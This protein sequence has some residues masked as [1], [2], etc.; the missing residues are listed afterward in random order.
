MESRAKAL[1]SPVAGRY[2]LK[3]RVGS[4]NMS[5]VYRA[6]DRLQGNKTVAVKL[7]NS[8]HDDVLRQ[9]L[10]HRELRALSRV[11]HPNIVEVL[12]SGWSEEHQCHFLVL[13]YLPRTLAHEI[14]AHTA[15]PDQGWCWPLMRAMAAALA[16][17]HGEGIVHR[18]VKPSNV[19]MEAGAHPKLADFGISWLRFELSKGITVSS[20]W[21]VG[22]AAPE[23]RSQQRADER[24]DIYALGCVFYHL[25]ARSEPPADGPHDQEIEALTVPTQ[26]MRLLRRMLAQN[27]AD[28]FQDMTQVC[29][30]LDATRNMELLPDVYL[31]VT[32][33]ARRDLYDLGL[34]DQTTT[35]AACLFLLEELG[36]DNPREVRML[37]EREDVRL[38]TET[39][40]LICTRDRSLPILVIKAVHAPYQPQ[41][42]QQK[43]LALSARYLW[44]VIDAGR[45]N[46]LPSSPALVGTLDHLS[47]RLSEQV[48]QLAAART[49]KR[50]RKDFL[51]TWGSAL[52]YL[53]EQLDAVGQLPYRSLSYDDEYVVF[54]LADPAPDDLP[55]PTNA[56]VV[57]LDPARPSNHSF[58]GHVISIL[59]RTV[60]VSRDAG[61]M[62]HPLEAADQLPQVGA[63][64][65]FQQEAAVSLE[66]QQTALDLILAGA[67]V[68]PRLP[69]VAR[70]LSLAT[71][72]D[73]DPHFA[74]F[75][76]HLGPDQQRAVRLALAAQDLFVLQGPPGTGKTT[77][78]A[79]IILQIVRKQP[80]AR[81][82]VA[83]QSNVA[84]N[85]I[86]SCLAEEQGERPIEIVRIGRAEKIGHGA[87]AW[88]IEQR[89]SAW[90]EQ[91][92]QRTDEVLSTLKVRLREQRRA[93][94]EQQLANQTILD[95]LQQCQEWLAEL[96]R[97]LEH[98]PHLSGEEEDRE[99]EDLW[100]TLALIRATL[101]EA[102]QG[103]TLPSLHEEHQRL[104]QAVDG[105]L[106][107]AFPET[108]ESR[109]VTLVE[110]W[111][112]IFGRDA[113]FARPILE[114]ASILASTCLI[115]GGYYLKDQVFDWAIIDEAG[116]ATTPE[117]LVALVRARRAIIVGDERQLP[118]MLDE[119][120]DDNALARL[121]TSREQLAESLFALLSTQGKEAQLPAVQML[122]TQYRMSP[123]IGK[124]VSAVFYGGQLTHAVSAQERDHQLPWLER[125]VAWFST[126]QLPRFGET[127]QGKSYYNRAEIRVISALLHRIERT[128]REQG[129]HR[130]V[131]VITPYNAQIVELVAEII[132][133]SSFWQSLS[134]E[135]ATIDA[136]QGR[137]CDIVLY[138]TV[139]SNREGRLGFLRDRRRLNVALSRAREALLIVG[140]ISTLERGRAG[141][142]GNPYQELVRYLRTHPEDCLIASVSEEDLHG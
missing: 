41:L 7:L 98:L 63:L 122:T 129:L 69:E 108:Q 130:N 13:E 8:P 131:A 52:S 105:L 110:R 133:A 113:N 40:R 38:Y 81:I 89:L 44:Q 1:P 139:R 4:G 61:D 54:T 126:T 79:E 120:L 21:S 68:N 135:V 24:S 142:E 33:R 31:L 136:Y 12:D 56:P 25:L 37:L 34:I 70:D 112:K 104:K 27:P 106:D 35:E 36:G 109:L 91:V 115:A 101:P 127:R 134:V 114:R 3:E 28:R 66:R 84:V 50:E 92:V 96:E 121:G 17:A 48:A 10:F 23:Q 93:H 49:Q 47:V 57:V 77:T 86:L 124:L 39:L 118:P 46:Q 82:L 99:R 64:T 140:D 62:N 26:I 102:A 71:F 85:H 45:L 123:P 103:T 30:Q 5:T 29:R 74:F 76:Q 22:Y 97:R 11:E 2:V 59:G 78:L 138:S 65:I 72:H 119:E 60:E 18:D 83:S 20:F 87:Q 80:D 43:A 42:E 137:D 19:L 141:A 95:D 32:D 100:A 6:E 9:E 128:Y 88:T 73:P 58:V 94:K 55:W 75:Q 117:L 16:H 53:Q 67:T 111:R 90:R 132:P 15:D 107:P 116:R 14:E 125:A 51:R